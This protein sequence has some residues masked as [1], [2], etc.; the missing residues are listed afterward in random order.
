MATDSVATFSERIME[1][2]L[3]E[4]VDRFIRAGW[5][6]LSNLAYAS[7]AG[8]TGNEA[9][10]IREVLVKGLGDEGADH[11]HANVLKRLY[12]EAFM[13]AAQDLRAR[14]EPTSSVTPRQ[15]P[16]PER[17]ERRARIEKRLVGLNLRGE[18]EAS[19][20]LVDLCVNMYDNDYVE[21]IPLELCTKRDME[22]NRVTKDPF[23]A[24]SL[25]QDGTLRLNKISEGMVSVPD[26][27][28]AMSFAFQRRGT[29]LEQADVMQYETH[30]ALH[31]RLVHALMKPSEP[32]FA[33]IGPDQLLAADR[34]AWSL[35][36]EATRDGIKR[37]GSME[38]P[39]DIAM[40]AVMNHTEFIMA[41]MPRQ[42]PMAGARNHQS[43]LALLDSPWALGTIP[44][45]ASAAPA[46]GGP[47]KKN[48]GK[49]KGAKAEE[50]RAKKITNAFT[51]K[52]NP[53]AAPSRPAKVPRSDF[54]KLPAALIG[55]CPKSDSGKRLCFAFNLGSCNAAA[56]GQECAKGWHLC[57]KPLPSGHACSKPHGANRCTP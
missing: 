51:P 53:A 31:Q 14:T 42:I 2:G 18:L 33:K 40:R 15:L 22:V 25:G 30:E 26:C 49:R 23:F 3:A 12:Y 11:R 20:H 50:E 46:A 47:G 1:L 52:Q 29:A 34:K 7:R 5:F 35:L 4:H 13:L 10:F 57:M 8:Q 44:Q 41:L 9:D 6:T 54:V 56:P 24:T 39:C 28:Y 19:H 37:K 38:R 45:Q 43:Q 36:S 27:Q 32:G 55:M 16:Q 48:K 21:Y 17:R